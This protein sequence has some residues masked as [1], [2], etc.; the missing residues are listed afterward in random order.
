METNG[1]GWTVIQR[2]MDG[3]V[4]VYRNWT[5]YNE[6]FDNLSGEF[7]LGLNKIYIDLLIIE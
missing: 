3:F 7:W 6:G 4:D 2:R 1:G 5:D